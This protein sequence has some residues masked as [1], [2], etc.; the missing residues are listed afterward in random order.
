MEAGKKALSAVFERY[1]KA[2]LANMKK[3]HKNEEKLENFNAKLLLSQIRMNSAKRIHFFQILIRMVRKASPKHKLDDYKDT[4]LLMAN[5]RYLLQEHI[6]L[7]K[8]MVEDCKRIIPQI[9][10][11]DLKLMFQFLV[12]EEKIHE[13]LL[14]KIINQLTRIAPDIIP[15]F[16][17]SSQEN[18]MDN[19]PINSLQTYV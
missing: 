18:N 4:Y 16:Q 10:D 12:E 6:K 17:G 9:D 11:P 14:K 19:D 5:V 8:D 13:I 1:Y 7:E 2:E 15:E 3:C